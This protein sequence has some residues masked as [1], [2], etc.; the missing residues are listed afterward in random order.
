[1]RN[2]VCIGVRFNAF[3]GLH[4][5]YNSFKKIY[6][7]ENTHIQI[8]IEN[9]KWTETYRSLT[10][11]ITAVAKIY[12]AAPAVSALRSERPCWP[13]GSDAF[14]IN[15][16][17]HWSQPTKNVC[18]TSKK[19]T[20]QC[21]IVQPVCPSSSDSYTLVP[22]NVTT[23]TKIFLGNVTLIVQKYHVVDVD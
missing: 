15:A 13:R 1:M 21:S 19:P 11:Q 4:A 22:S 12:F 8:Q 17:L 14:E 10:W 2:C 20:R 9:F 3:R 5:P 18:L 16:R 6:P 7:V 23:T